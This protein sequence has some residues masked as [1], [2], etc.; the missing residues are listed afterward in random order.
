MNSFSLVPLLV[1]ICAEMGR[2]SF[3]F[4][5][6]CCGRRSRSDAATVR[7]RFERA[8]AAVAAMRAIVASIQQLRLSFATWLFDARCKK[9]SILLNSIVMH[10]FAGKDDAKARPKAHG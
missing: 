10:S 2:T 4:F 8:L 5:Q 9:S 6:S 7:T 3:E 1:G